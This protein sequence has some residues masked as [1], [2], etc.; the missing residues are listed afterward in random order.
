[1]TLSIADKNALNKIPNTLTELSEGYN[2]LVDDVQL[3]DLVEGAGA[4]GTATLANSTSTV[5]ADTRVKLGDQII[6]QA[7]DALGAALA[8]VFVDPSLINPGVNFTIEH[9]AAAGTEVF[10]YQI[11]R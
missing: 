7:Q 11:S 10:A 8:A 5:V 1:M 4:S 3:G 6:V 2:D 9:G